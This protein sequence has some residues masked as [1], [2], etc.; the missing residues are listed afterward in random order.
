M[1]NIAETVVWEEINNEI[2]ERRDGDVAV[3][4]ANPIKAKQI[5]W[6][7]PQKSI[8]EAVEDAWNFYSANKGA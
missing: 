4:V 2:G 6:W 7:E 8:V 3:S 1:L 5:L